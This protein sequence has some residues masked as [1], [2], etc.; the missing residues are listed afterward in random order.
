[1]GVRLVGWKQEAQPLRVQCLVVQA[2]PKV[3]SAERPAWIWERVSCVARGHPPCNAD[4]FAFIHL[5]FSHFH[6]ECISFS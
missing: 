5:A 1:M 2:A 6:F 4:I 3:P